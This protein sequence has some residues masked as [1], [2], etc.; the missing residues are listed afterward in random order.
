MLPARIGTQ[1]R[2]RKSM[3]QNWVQF[4][5]FSPEI[6]GKIISKTDRNH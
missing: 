5:G 6:N 4:M 1:L 2:K 3:E